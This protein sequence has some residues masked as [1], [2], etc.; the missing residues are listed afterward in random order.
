MTI[1]DPVFTPGDASYL[2]DHA[3][4]VVLSVRTE[5]EDDDP[6]LRVVLMHGGS[7]S[8]SRLSQRIMRPTWIQ[9][10]ICR[11]ATC[12]SLRRF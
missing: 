8:R 12:L 5:K 3:G 9:W 6:P 1:F 2:R 4:Y 11:I 7:R 10:Y